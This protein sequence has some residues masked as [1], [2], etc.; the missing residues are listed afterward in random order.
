MYNQIIRIVCLQPCHISITTAQF[1]LM[2][3]DILQNL[4][5]GE[6]KSV[7]SVSRLIIHY[8]I[9]VSTPVHISMLNVQ[10]RKSGN[11]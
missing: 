2:Q 8:Q 5:Y 9:E 7:R 11:G 3:P 1:L 10:P 4:E 6:L